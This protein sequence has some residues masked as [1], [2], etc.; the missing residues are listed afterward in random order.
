MNDIT[1]ADPGPLDVGA[2]RVISRVQPGWHVLCRTD[3]GAWEWVEV[4]VVLSGRDLLAR[5]PVRRLTLVDGSEV[6]A[7][8]DEEVVCRTA[9]EA[10]RAARIDAGAAAT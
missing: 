3:G 2:Y 10:K 8:A 7:Y 1:T 5:R 9:V 4:R 6:R